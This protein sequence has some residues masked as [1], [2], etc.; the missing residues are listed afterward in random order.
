MQSDASTLEVENI[1]Q[2]HA[3]NIDRRTVGHKSDDVSFNP[4]ASIDM[5]DC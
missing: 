2:K 1:E 4:N 3:A 5:D